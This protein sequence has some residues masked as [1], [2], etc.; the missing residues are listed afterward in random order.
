M[1]V[2]AD[3][4]DM[5]RMSGSVGED[6][7]HT[8]NVVGFSGS[9]SEGATAIKSP[10]FELDGRYFSGDPDA[11]LPSIHTYGRE[12]IEE[13]QERG[14]LSLVSE[15]RH[16]AP[17]YVFIYAQASFLRP[18]P[19]A[20]DL[21]CEL[22]TLW[23]DKRLGAYCDYM[24]RD[25]AITLLGRWAEALLSHAKSKFEESSFLE[26]KESAMRAR[27]GATREHL[28]LR[29][30]AHC[31]VAAARLGLGQE[32]HGVI[33]NVAIDFS[34]AEADRVERRAR[35]LLNQLQLWTSS[36]LADYRKQDRFTVR[37]AGGTPPPLA[38]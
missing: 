22:D 32:I 37:F 15:R 3:A 6:A 1:A 5:A 21:T 9:V 16:R 18:S 12:Q 23:W 27:F 2:N 29:K 30:K 11:P 4:S 8:V 31:Y 38:A 10:V 28:E 17:G 7:N 33:R 13:Y 24:H 14:L 35:G 34:K 25:R 26:A 19:D 20:Y 36:E